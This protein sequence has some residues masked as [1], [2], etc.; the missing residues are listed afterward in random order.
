MVI[1]PV[2]RHVG[3]QFIY[4]LGKQRYLHL[5]RAGI[6]LVEGK[7]LYDF[8]LLGLFQIVLPLSCVLRLT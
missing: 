6:S 3:G 5:S 8:L 7:I 1:V 2:S 4:S